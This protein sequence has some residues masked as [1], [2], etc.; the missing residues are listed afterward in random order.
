[1]EAFGFY[2]TISKIIITVILAVFSYFSQKHFS[3]KVRK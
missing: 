1:V 2:P 3:F